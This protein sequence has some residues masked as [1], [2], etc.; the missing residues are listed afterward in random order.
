MTNHTTEEWENSKI[1][2]FANQVRN[3]GFSTFFQFFVVCLV[4]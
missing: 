3:Q 1:R 2:N 4:I